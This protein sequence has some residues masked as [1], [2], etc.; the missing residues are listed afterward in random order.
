MEVDITAWLGMALRWLHII[1]GIAWIGS[2]FFFIWLDNSLKAPENKEDE[3][4]GVGGELWAVHGGGFYHKKKYQVAPSFMPDDLHWFKWEAYFTWI[5]GFLLLA[6][7]YYA[8]AEIYLIDSSKMILE[9]WE[10]IVLS[11][12]FIAGGWLFYDILCKSKAGQNTS[13]FWIIWYLALVVMSYV[14]FSIF[15][16]RGA[17]IHIGAVVG[18]VMAFNVFMVI[19]PNQKKVVASLLAGEKPNPKLGKIAKQRST[20]NNYMT[21]PV[22]L[23]MVSNHYPMM[24]GHDYNWLI[25]AGLGAVAFPVRHFFNLKHKG[26]TNYYY[27]AAGVAGFILIMLLASY[28]QHLKHTAFLAQNGNVPLITDKQ[29]RAIIKERCVLCH[30]HN[31]RHEDFSVPPSDL[32]LDT[33]Y[34]IKKNAELIYEQSVVNDIMPQGNETGMTDDERRALGVWLQSLQDKK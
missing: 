23:I 14:L 8:G 26:I 19:I 12:G 10:A 18:S 27:P 9:P 16:D 15:N 31:P 22:L 32:S 28:Q 20:H 5:S 24:V 7:I 21:L 1:T 13:L 33:M 30:S 25:L 29:A 6:L 34:D 11:L 4:A 2:S 3:E 17:F